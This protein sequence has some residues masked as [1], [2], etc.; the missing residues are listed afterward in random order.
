M[1][2]NNIIFILA[3]IVSTVFAVAPFEPTW[4]NIEYKKSIDV[5]KSF[6]KEKH[7]ITIKNID[8]QPN[9]K[10][11]FGVPKEKKADIALNIVV[12]DNKS[13]KSILQPAPLPLE[14]PE[15]AYFQLSLP[16]PIA[17]GSTFHFFI[18]SIITNQMI[19]YP[20][21][22]SMTDDQVLKVTTNAYPISPYNTLSYEFAITNVNSITE[23]NADNLPIPLKSTEQSRGVIY[24]TE[25]GVN[26]NTIAN[27]TF[28]Y[29]RNAPLA[30]INYL[31][32]DLWVSH[33]SSKLQL[34]EYYEL[35]NHA[36]KLDEGFSRAK[37]FSNQLGMKPHHPI[38]ALR[39]PFDKS[40][41]IEDG[42][43]YYTD[44]VGNVSTSQY[45]DSE[46]LLRP[47]F[48][49]FGGWNYNF[50]IGWNYDLSQ[51]VKRQGDEYILKANI[52]DGIYDSTYG[53]VKFSIY[54]PEGAEIIDYALPFGVEEPVITHEFSYL[55]VTDG[56]VKI[57]FEFENVVDEMKN[58]VLVLRYRYTSFAMLHKPLHAAF[59]VFIALMALYLLKKIDLSVRP[60][61]NGVF[62]ETEGERK[63]E[64]PE[65]QTLN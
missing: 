61:R 32:R 17:P 20:E 31:Q 51:F 43:I 59:Y 60:M 28:T 13:K 41:T 24:S 2:T 37:Y 62:L 19:P 53:N 45:Y 14:D 36:A 54:L 3:W 47:R 35:T 64:F 50:T 25:D 27:F 22:I 10:Y 29:V 11:I 57:S 52:L 42:S 18:S 44:K 48:P 30:Y 9:S 49:L 16:F 40:K 8:S 58:L 34:E 23:I 46:L 6:L 5:G 12:Y 63:D 56:H 15:V 65:D 26:A 7:E 39:V 38:T 1:K 4:E 21:Y 33:W 55:D